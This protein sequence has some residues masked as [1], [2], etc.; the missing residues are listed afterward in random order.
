MLS[1]L[2]YKERSGTLVPAEAVRVAAFDKARQVR[3]SL[4]NIPSRL[5]PILAAETNAKKVNEILTQEIRQCL[6]VLSG[7]LGN[8]TELEGKEC[9]N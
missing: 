7:D 2:E 3:D 5:S 9:Q 8:E 4:L 6:E 1:E